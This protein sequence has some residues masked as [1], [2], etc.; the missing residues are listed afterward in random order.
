MDGILASFAQGQCAS[1][2]LQ[3]STYPYLVPDGH[4]ATTAYYGTP[5]QYAPLGWVGNVL[6]QFGQ[7]PGVAGGVFGGQ[8]ANLN[9][10]TGGIQIPQ[11]TQPIGLGFGQQ[12]N[13]GWPSTIPQQ[14]GQGWLGNSMGPIPQPIGLG[15]ASGIGVPQ[16]ASALGGM[17]S[18][19][20]AAIPGS[21]TQQA[22]QQVA[23]Q[24]AQAG[25]LVGL[26]VAQQAAQQAAQ[27][28]AHQVACQ[29]AH[30]AQQAAF[31][32][33][34]AAQQVGQQGA[35]QVALQGAQQVGAQQAQQA[36]LQASQAAQQVA[37]QAAH[38]AAQQAAQQVAQQ[39]AQ[40]AQQA[41]YQVTQQAAAACAAQQA[42][43]PWDSPAIQSIAAQQWVPLA[44]YGNPWG[45]TYQPY[46]N[47][48]ALV[49]G[50]P[51][52]A[53]AFGAFGGQPLGAINPLAALSASG[54]QGAY[55]GIGQSPSAIRA[56]NPFDAYGAGSLGNQV[57]FTPAPR[58]SFA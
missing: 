28:T 7:P 2:G 9:P 23:Q 26:Q 34:Q 57:Q 42:Y 56:V 52:Y 35:Q 32:A 22:A 17:G 51:Q 45:Q 54:F 49:P 21:L 25:Q 10:F 13:M 18:Q 40:A 58:F 43:N 16:L 38:Q 37:H 1:P 55:G 39:A 5:Q 41:G 3:Y 53:G 27:R 31:Q 20:S 14:L 4:S 8:F 36:A 50:Y 44:G 12:T 29:A 19:F 11:W 30:A 46:A 15:F 48:G 6:S 24:A 33:A 47:I